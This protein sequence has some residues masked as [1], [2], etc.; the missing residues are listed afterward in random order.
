MGTL[1][2]RT[3]HRQKRRAMEKYLF[4][5]FFTSTLSYWSKFTPRGTNSPL[6]PSCYLAL[7]AATGH[8]KAYVSG[9]GFL[10]M[11]YRAR[12]SQQEPGTLSACPPTTSQVVWSNQHMSWGLSRSCSALCLGSDNEAPGEQIRRVRGEAWGV[13]LMSCAVSR[14]DWRNFYRE[15][16]CQPGERLQHNFPGE[17]L[18]WNLFAAYKNVLR[19]RGSSVALSKKPSRKVHELSLVHTQLEN[20][21]QCR[22]A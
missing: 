6:L 20:R 15:P 22:A 12:E 7:W 18:L 17:F 13:V 1:H 3:V 8:A 10:W 5:C 11:S 16:H 4:A 19:A 2:L 9:G 14:G 21:D